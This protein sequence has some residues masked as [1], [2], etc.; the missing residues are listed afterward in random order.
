MNT[1]I[2]YRP[3]HRISRI[4]RVARRLPLLTA[5]LPLL[6]GLAACAEAPQPLADVDYSGWRQS[7][8]AVLN[9]P[10]PGHGPGLRRIFV[11]DAGFETGLAEDGS[12]SYPTGT[13]FVKEVYGGPDP[14]P[15]ADPAMLTVMIKA[16][17]DPRSRGGWI[18]VVR[19]PESG[20]ETVF[21]EEFCVTCHANANEEHPYGTGNTGERFRDYVFHT[22]ALE[23]SAP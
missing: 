8:S 7:T 5:V 12:I 9:F 20:E 14:A 22:P 2:A 21:D 19:N 6:M 18:W 1:P 10:V 3:G 13:I 17:G 23:A 16:P 4:S 11:N 15:G